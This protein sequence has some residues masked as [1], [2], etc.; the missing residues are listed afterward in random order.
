MA[1]GTQELVP[2]GTRA[3]VVGRLL[4][5]GN[6]LARTF[7]SE[8][9]ASHLLARLDLLGAGKDLELLAMAAFLRVRTSHQSWMETETLAHGT[10]QWA[11]ASIALFTVH[12]NPEDKRQTDTEPVPDS[13]WIIAPSGNGQV[14]QM[15]DTMRRNA[16]GTIM[17]K[18]EGQRPR[19]W[20]PGTAMVGIT[21]LAETFLS[22]C[23]MYRDSADEEGRQLG[24]G[25]IP[26]A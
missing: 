2:L 15:L 10:E 11:S 6:H 18:G 25:G 23:R 26:G 19:G 8:L 24:R 21:V 9:P 20:C 16:L 1:F 7:P 5:C 13:H 12:N 22:M 4:R 14:Y 3:V 17:E